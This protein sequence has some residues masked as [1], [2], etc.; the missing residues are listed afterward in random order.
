MAC[1]CAQIVPSAFRRQAQCVS[2]CGAQCSFLFSLLLF[3][4]AVT[5][6]QFREY[7]HE[8]MAEGPV[9]EPPRRPVALDTK[10]ELVS[11][12]AAAESQVVA[13]PATPLHRFADSLDTPRMRDMRASAK[14]KNNEEDAQLYLGETVVRMVDFQGVQTS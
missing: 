10:R 11:Q 9:F 6:K 14:K 1:G 7:L 2:S 13:A 3:F 4:S 12:D 8:K 5:I